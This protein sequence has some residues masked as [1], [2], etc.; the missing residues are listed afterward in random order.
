VTEELKRKYYIRV[1]L[2]LGIKKQ[3]SYTT[4]LRQHKGFALQ[5]EYSKSNKM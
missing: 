4:A 5:K 1:N 2:P 3:K